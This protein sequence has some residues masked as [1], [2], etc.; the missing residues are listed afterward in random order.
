MGPIKV[1]IV[2]DHAMFRVALAHVLRDRGFDVVA[3]AADAATG[4][5]TLSSA[6]PDVVLLD[7]RLPGMDG[8][9]L[10]RR[11]TH[12]ANGPK[13]MIVSAFAQ[14]HDVD[15][16]W[17][18]GAHGYVSKAAEIEQLT[19]GI[20]AVVAGERW[21]MPGL[22]PPRALN[23]SRRPLATGPLGT[24]SARERDVFRHVVRGQTAREIAAALG[25]GIKTVETH[26][27]RILKKL[28]LHSVIDLVRMA[29]QNQLLDD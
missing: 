6:R 23:R 3:Q 18:A 9:T 28:A 12:A 20:R 16:A 25:I 21:L 24:L 1:G 10:T 15:E 13:V 7:L 8:V 17:A 29:A 4:M 27:E 11:L 2:D 26:R 19:Q 14:Q 5:A 22:P